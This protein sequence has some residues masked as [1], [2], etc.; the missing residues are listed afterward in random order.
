MTSTGLANC[1]AG[2]AETGQ[3]K[4]SGVVVDVSGWTIEHGNGGIGHCERERRR[5]LLCSRSVTHQNA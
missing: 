1:M 2:A 3:A 5:V 4:D